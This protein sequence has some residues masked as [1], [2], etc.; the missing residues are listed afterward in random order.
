M[1]TYTHT[2]RTTAPVHL[3][4]RDPDDYTRL[5]VHNEK[6]GMIDNGAI[7]EDRPEHCYNCD[8]VDSLFSSVSLHFC[9]CGLIFNYWAGGGNDKWHNHYKKMNQA[10][11]RQAAMDWYDTDG[12]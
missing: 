11:E 1:I 9:K 5:I 2:H 7:T 3:L 12:Y 10:R 6:N 8:T 4:R